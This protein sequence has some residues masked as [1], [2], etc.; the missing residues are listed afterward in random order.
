MIVGARQGGLSISE[1]LF[2]WDSHTQQSL[3]FAEHGAK[4]KTHPVSISSLGRNTF[5]NEQGQRRGARLVKADSNGKNCTL[6]QWYAEEHPW[7][8][9]A[10]NL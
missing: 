2:S 8:R 4:S 10:S 7:T 6:Q 9:N 5:V 3:E 1:L